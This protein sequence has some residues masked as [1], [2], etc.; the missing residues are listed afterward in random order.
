[1]K[2]LIDSNSYTHVVAGHTS[3]G[4][5]CFPRLAALID[6]SQISDI[7]ALEGEDIFERPI[8]A[9]NAIAKVKSSDKVKV[10]TVRGTAFEAC[11]EE[12]GNAESEEVKALE[13]EG[14]FRTNVGG[15]NLRGD[16]GG[17]EIRLC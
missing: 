9:G 10:F 5:D 16:E 15:E 4:R 12:G 7:T 17:E 3:V 11:E 13:T 6:S 2:S 1:M 8:Y 14:E